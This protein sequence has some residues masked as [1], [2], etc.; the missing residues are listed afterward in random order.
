MGSGSCGLLG[1]KVAWGGGSCACLH[2]RIQYKTCKLTISLSASSLPS[3]YSLAMLLG[4]STVLAVKY[5]TLSNGGST[6]AAA[7][8]GVTLLT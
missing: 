7:G 2:I 4:A 6:R 8:T 1:L 5:P 3:A